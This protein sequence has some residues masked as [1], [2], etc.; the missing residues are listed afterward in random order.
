V[1]YDIVTCLYRIR[2]QN[3]RKYDF[4]QPDFICEVFGPLIPSK[5][6]RDDSD[7]KDAVFAWCADATAVEGKYGHISK[8]NTS[9]VTNMF[10]LFSGKD[11]DN[12][13]DD[14]SKWDVSNV[15]NMRKMFFSAHVFGKDISQWNVSKVTTMEEMFGESSF[16]GDI[17]KWNVSKVTDMRHMFWEAG[18]F[19]AD[20]S[21]WDVSSVTKMSSMFHRADSF[22]REYISDWDVSGVTDMEWIFKFRMTL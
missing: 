9:K 14:I 11:F 6:I 1:R 21:G 22:N 3:E 7:I 13:N 10:N 4:L 18:Y 15:T 8:W 2:K 20:I 19:D 17:S 12:D 5:F 16:N